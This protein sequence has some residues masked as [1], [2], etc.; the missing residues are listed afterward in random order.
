MRGVTPRY[1]YTNARCPC[2]AGRGCQIRG[3]GRGD[4]VDR[5]CRGTS[6]STPKEGVV[7][8]LVQSLV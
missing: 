5:A 7:Q 8:V 6:V 3:W 4:G 1:L 2:D